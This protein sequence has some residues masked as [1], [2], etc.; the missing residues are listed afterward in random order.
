LPC[1]HIA[2]TA[3]DNGESDEEDDLCSMR[4]FHTYAEGESDGE[5]DLCSMRSFH[6]DAAGESDGEE[7]VCS[8]QSFHTYAE[9]ETDDEVALRSQFIIDL[10]LPASN[11]R[12]VDTLDCEPEPRCPPLI[13]HA[14]AGRGAPEAYIKA[15]CA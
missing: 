3:F 5:D 12:W 6:T 8:L 7:D 14:H 2:F 13:P 10:D 1:R 15:A 9:D 4:S 11:D